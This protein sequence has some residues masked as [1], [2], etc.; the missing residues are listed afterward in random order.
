MV[1]CKDN[2]PLWLVRNDSICLF[3]KMSLQQGKWA[4]SSYSHHRKLMFCDE[5]LLLSTKR[6]YLL[7]NCN[8]C[9]VWVMLKWQQHGEQLPSQL[10][11]HY[12]INIL[13]VFVSALICGTTLQFLYNWPWSFLHPDRLTCSVALL[14]IK[15]KK[16]SYF[17]SICI[18]FHVLPL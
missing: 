13:V 18:I 7:P 12:M 15:W 1:P 6:V 9:P 2:F 14:N 16:V 11:S 3:I 4:A 10:S 8:I 17:V 5:Q